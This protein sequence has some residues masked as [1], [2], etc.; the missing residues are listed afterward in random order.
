LLKR[1]NDLET[2]EP[3]CDAY[4]SLRPR[5]S[6]V[7]VVQKKYEPLQRFA[8]SQLRETAEAVPKMQ[9]AL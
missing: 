7:R 3:K 6:E 9:E 2:R 1:G 4:S 8:T 5:F